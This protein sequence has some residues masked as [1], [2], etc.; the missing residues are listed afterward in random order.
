MQRNKGVFAGLFLAMIVSSSIFATTTRESGLAVQDAPW[1]LDGLEGYVNVNPSL[2]T[3]FNNRVFAERTMYSGASTGLNSGSLFI[4]PF[5]WLSF[6]LS[7]GTPVDQVVWNS[8]ELESL[9]HIGNYSAKG[10]NKKY[11]SIESSQK[12]GAYQIEMLDNTII[13]IADPD[14]ATAVVGDNAASPSIRKHL[15]QQNISL[16]SGIDFGR[17]KVGISAGYASSVNEK[18]SNTSETLG[19][20]SESYKF[21]NNEYSASA[22]AKLIFNEKVSLDAFAKY[23]GYDLYNRYQSIRVTSG[24]FSYCKATY[25]SD[26]AM[27]V[28]FGGHIGYKMTQSQKTHFYFKYVTQNRS[29]AGT[30]VMVN[31]SSNSSYDSN[32]NDSFS[33]IGRLISVGVSDEIEISESHRIFLGFYV[34]YSSY[35]NKYSGKDFITSANNL[36]EYSNNWKKLNVPLIAGFEGQLTDNLTGRFSIK[37][38]IYRPYSD[39]GSNVT[40]SATSQ[41]K[42]PVENNQNACSI[43]TLNIGVS[44]RLEKFQ[45]DWLGSLD[46]VIDGPFASS[47]KIYTDSDKTPLSTSF[48]ASFKFDSYLNSEDSK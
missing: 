10:T 41:V 34:D 26:G 23:V 22:G 25:K 40:N 28:S 20:N 37:Q 48:A 18:N 19:I 46:R 42:N 2:I 36:N 21:S 3:E 29:T 32:A 11:H 12:L 7:I 17:L 24:D 31:P 30:F 13:D 8:S 9:F 35:D 15:D 6:G 16:I 5:S 14:N 39:S 47:G 38:L 33:R 43:T 1:F 45:F 44:Y 4:A 27:D